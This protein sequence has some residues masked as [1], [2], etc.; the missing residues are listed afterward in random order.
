MTSFKSR[1]VVKILHSDN[2]IIPVPIHTKDIKKG[3]IKGIIKQAKSDEKEFT[4]LK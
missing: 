3:L 4:K 2:T 1:E